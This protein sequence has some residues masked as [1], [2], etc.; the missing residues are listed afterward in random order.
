MKKAYRH[1]KIIF[2]IGPATESEEMLEKLIEEGVDICRIN[3]AHADH[4]WTRSVVTRIRKVAEKVGREIAIMMDVKG[5]EIRTCPLDEPII[6]EKEQR[7][8]LSTDANIFTFDEE[9]FPVLGVNYTS[10]IEDLS[11][12][13]EVLVDNGLLKFKVIGKT[14]SRI[15]CQVLIGGSLG[16]RRHINL[17]GVK[18]NL[19]AITEKDKGD[20]KVGLEVEVD[21]FALS[22]VRE[23]T[24]IDTL[25]EYLVSIGSQAKIV[26]KIEDQSAITN[27]DE[28]ILA[29]DSLMVAR[30]DLG[31]ECPYEELPIIQK[32]A[33]KKCLQLGKHVIIA[34]HM[35]ES[36]IEN[37]VPTRAEVT[38][39]SNA[40]FERADCIMLSGETTIGKFPL[41][42]V[43]VF[44]RIAVRMESS[45]GA[46]F[47]QG[48]ILKGPRTMMLR[49]AKILA[50]ELGDAPILVFT[51]TGRFGEILA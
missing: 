33:V 21:Q 29:A 28:I 23:A 7:V 43:R 14:K 46:G 38:D 34:T 35:L 47:A 36:M 22:F 15:Q 10:L 41:E 25:R 12:G 16:S 42:C 2:T 6:L 26:A 9:G 20:I 24:D 13:N 50:E 49:S 5:P 51:K 44:N 48:R 19:P 27:L 30:G 39:V 37:P 32:L 4:D 45:E 11:V 1:T 17:P 8:D 18:V 31:I 3:M 40:V